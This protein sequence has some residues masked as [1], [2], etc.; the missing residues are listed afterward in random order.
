MTEETLRAFARAIAADSLHGTDYLS[1]VET[2]D[3]EGIE[4]TDAEAQEI[5]D[6][7]VSAEVTLRG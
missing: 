7:I 5:H 3:D 4:Y 2:L 1:V 6:L